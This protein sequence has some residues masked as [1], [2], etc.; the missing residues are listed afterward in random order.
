MLSSISAT[1]RRQFIQSA[2]VIGAGAVLTSSTS[3]AFAETAAADQEGVN[4]R[5]V[6][7]GA[8]LPAGVAP[9]KKTTSVPGK[10]P[11]APPDKQGAE[12]EVPQPVKRKV[13]FAIVGL[14]KLAI[15][16]ILPAF[17]ESKLSRPV[18]LV[19]GHP[20][21]AKQLA[22]VY[23]VDAKKIYNY[24]N[25][26]SLAD[27]AA[28]DVIYIVL[29]N[30]MHAEYT[31]RGF[32]AGKHVLCEKPMAVSVDECEKMIAAADQAKRHL[33]IA[34]RLHYEPFNTKVMDLCKSGA[35]GKIRT[36]ASAH[37]QNVESPNIRLSAPLGGGAVGDLGIYCINAARYTIGEEPI[38]VTA[39]ATQSSD[40]PRFREVPES[41]VLTMKFPSGALAHCETSMSTLRSDWYC[42]TGTEGVI[43]MDPAFAYRGQK[44]FT[45]NPD[46]K[47]EH[48]VESANHFAEEMDHIAQCVLDGKT[49]RTSGAEGLADLKIIS[50]IDQAI[51][52]GQ[53]VAVG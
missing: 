18:A 43:E 2:G 25:Y 32:Q 11:L 1:N 10:V 27:D 20:D 45:V 22:E 21:K 24:E 23:G 51:R 19:S 36:F 28:V 14:G 30:S 4:P 53:T 7:Q 40:D 50:A 16:E 44:L 35:I 17:A 3:R 5:P 13:G 15:E 34:Y 33:M 9:D 42:V 26:D 31:I 39:V 48:Q 46:G 6:G 52:T 49:P 38:S 47:T 8:G 41:V 37:C 29:P 12:V